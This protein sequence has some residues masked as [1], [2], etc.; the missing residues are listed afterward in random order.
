MDDDGS[1]KKKKPIY[2][3]KYKMI[4]NFFDNVDQRYLALQTCKKSKK[5]IK[6]RFMQVDI[7]RKYFN[8]T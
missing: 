1:K 2:S 3:E 7:N 6:I 8:V 5:M 4:M